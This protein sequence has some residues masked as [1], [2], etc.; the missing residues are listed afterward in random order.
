M[1]R[2]NNHGTYF[3]FEAY[4]KAPRCRL[5]RI[6]FRSAGKWAIG[7]NLG[8]TKIEVALVAAAGDMP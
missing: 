4:S 8:G 3:W 7:V 5:A 6:K 2:L 1:A